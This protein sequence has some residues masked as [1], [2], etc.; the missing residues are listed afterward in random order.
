[1]RIRLA[2]GDCPVHN[3]EKC[4]AIAIAVASAEQRA[5]DS[6][7]PNLLVATDRYAIAGDRLH[8]AV[9]ASSRT[10]RKAKRFTR[11]A[12]DS[13]DL[14]NATRVSA[15]FKE[16]G[17]PDVDDFQGQLERYQPLAQRQHVRVVVSSR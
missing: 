17:Q 8:S 9:Q 2:A 14:S 1:M 16:R 11:Y 12:S 15:A 10:A 3:T 7:E 4:F 6:T 5:T 13:I